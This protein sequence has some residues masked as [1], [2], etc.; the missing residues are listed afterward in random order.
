[1]NQF[2]YLLHFWSFKILLLLTAL[3]SA[4]N[5]LEIL[6]N[7]SG[8]VKRRRDIQL[9]TEYTEWGIAEFLVQN[10]VRNCFLYPHLEMNRSI[11]LK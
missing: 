4:K 7:S 9:S 3:Y 10:L 6:A 5:P 11:L 8:F 2:T 1:M